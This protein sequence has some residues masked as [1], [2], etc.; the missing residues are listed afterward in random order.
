MRRRPRESPPLQT[1]FVAPAETV[2]GK[3]ALSVKEATEL[4][5]REPGDFTANCTPAELQRLCFHLTNSALHD[6]QLPSSHI[7]ALRS[8]RE[9]QL[10]SQRCSSQGSKLTPQGQPSDAARGPPARTH[11]LGQIS[12]E[13]EGLRR[14]QDPPSISLLWP[15]L[16]YSRT[17][18]EI[19][20]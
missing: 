13:A 20:R 19:H 2:T 3:A 15:S 7:R 1:H 6:A 9:Y 18:K 11:G 10:A 5:S 12:R 17:F 8:V 4:S 16:R 14:R